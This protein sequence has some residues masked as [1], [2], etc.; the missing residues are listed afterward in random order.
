[1][2]RLGRP[3]T[4][5]TRPWQRRRREAVSEGDSAGQEDASQDA[6]ATAYHTHSRSA[7]S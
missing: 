2:C 3:S 1:M 5:A 7:L 4:A 6:A